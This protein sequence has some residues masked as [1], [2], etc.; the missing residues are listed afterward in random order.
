MKTKL[1]IRQHPRTHE[2]EFYHVCGSSRIVSSTYH[3]ENTRYPNKCPVCFYQIPG[4]YLMGGRN[5]EVKIAASNSTL[6]RGSLN[7]IL[8]KDIDFYELIPIPDLL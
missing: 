1:Y 5:R 8:R 3:K 7:N 6:R 4:I 2:Y